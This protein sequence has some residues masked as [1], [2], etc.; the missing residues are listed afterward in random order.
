MPVVIGDNKQ[1]GEIVSPVSKM[2]ATV[3]DALKVFTGGAAGRRKNEAAQTL[4]QQ[5]ITKNVTQN[6]N[7][8]NTFEGSKDVQKTTSTAMRQSSRDITSELANALA[9]AR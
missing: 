5:S 9:Y 1:E 2:K 6:V 4:E 8:Y 7:I 3:L